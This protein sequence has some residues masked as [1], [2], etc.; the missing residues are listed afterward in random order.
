TN[1]GEAPILVRRVVSSCGCV[2]CQWQGGIVGPGEK[3]DVTFQ[4]VEGAWGDGSQERL[5]GFVMA[6]CSE[7]AVSWRGE[8]VRARP[9]CNIGF[10]PS[11]LFISQPCGKGAQGQIDRDIR[12]EL[13]NPNV[14]DPLVLTE[15]RWLLVGFRRISPAE[16][17][18]RVTVI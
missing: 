11:S 4:V 3:R 6:D 16:G 13:E 12:L 8:G 7:K 5:T 9:G 17:S 18:I 10:A 2:V 14:E 1:S 15:E